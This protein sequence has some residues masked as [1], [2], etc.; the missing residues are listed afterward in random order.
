M[1]SPGVSLRGCIYPE[2]AE[3]IY[4]AGVLVTQAPCRQV[5][6]IQHNVTPTRDVPLRNLYV[7]V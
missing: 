4:S 6:S 3:L 5:D 1:T 2:L 7:G